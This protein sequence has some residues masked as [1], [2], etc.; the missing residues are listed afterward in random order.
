MALTEQPLQGSSCLPSERV[1]DAES[2]S[3]PGR[4]GE[5]Q[6]F[7]FKAVSDPSIAVTKIPKRTT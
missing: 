6:P 3:K 5:A 1:L 4:H 7:G 2:P